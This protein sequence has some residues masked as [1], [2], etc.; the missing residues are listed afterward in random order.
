MKRQRIDLLAMGAYGH[1]RVRQFIVGSTTS[2]MV[3]TCLIPVML[4]R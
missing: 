1:S 3:R 4:F 2:S